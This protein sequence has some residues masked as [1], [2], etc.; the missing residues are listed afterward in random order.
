MHLKVRK[1]IKADFSYKRALNFIQN[2]NN[3]SRYQSKLKKP[4]VYYE[5]NDSGYY[6][7]GGNFAGI[8]WHGR[9]TFKLHKN[10]L[11]ITGAEGFPAGNMHGG[12][13][14]KDRGH[15]CIITHFED[16]EVPLMLLT[17][18]PLISFYLQIEMNKE[19]EVLNNLIAAE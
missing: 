10:G 1:S 19:M 3:I 16:Y 12:F 7:T 14:I 17:W 4:R 18:Y 6:I 5:S 13:F 2:I 8:P 15:K 9:F 11:N